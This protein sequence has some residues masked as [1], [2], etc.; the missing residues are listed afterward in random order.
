V[1]SLRRPSGII[2]HRSKHLGPAEMTRQ[3]GI[4]VTRPARTIFDIAPRLDDRQ[5]ARA[6][7]S[8]LHSRFLTRG[9]LAEQLLRHPGHPAAQRLRYFI[10]TDD[11]P[12]RSD[13]E[14]ALPAFCQRYDLPVPLFARR[15]A[16]HE[17]DAVWPAEK[18]V[19]ELDSWEFH[20]T[21]VDFESDRDRD[22]DRLVAGFITVRL[23]W[24]RIVG[25]PDRE[26]ARLHL[27]LADRRREAA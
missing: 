22:V 27:I 5:L 25:K 14:R 6:V 1:P 15:V 13:W 16:G 19:L 17:A 21:R 12:T 11:G 9:H 20:S 23:T 7:N 24:E 8:A 4:R 26:A 3:L 10:V 2:V 18:V